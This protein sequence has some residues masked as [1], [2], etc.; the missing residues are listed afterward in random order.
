MDSLSQIFSPSHSPT[1]GTTINQIKHSTD[2]VSCECNEASPYTI[3]YISES[4]PSE[5]ASMR[6][7]NHSLLFY[8]GDLF[9]YGGR[10][11]QPTALATAIS[12]TA[13]EISKKHKQQQR[14]KTNSHSG[15]PS[16]EVHLPSVYPTM[17]SFD[18]V[19]SAEF[20]DFGG[21]SGSQVAT[22]K[23]TTSEIAA[24]MAGEYI[25]GVWR[26][27]AKLRQWRDCQEKASKNRLLAAASVRLESNSSSPA[28][29]HF[30]RK[31]QG[32]DMPYSVLN[33]PTI[34][35]FVETHL[36]TPP[37]KKS[38]SSSSSIG[39][40][41]ALAS[42][43][44]GQIGASFVDMFSPP[45]PRGDH[46][47]NIVGHHMLI[48]GG[49]KYRE[50][51]DDLFAFDF[52][53]RVWCQL[54]HEKEFGPGPTFSHASVVINTDQDFMSGMR[55]RE[56]HSP[57]IRRQNA[58]LFVM[59]G[60]S[61]QVR[62]GTQ[63]DGKMLFVYDCTKNHWDSFPGPSKVDPSQ[64]H[65][66]EMAHVPCR[67][68]NFAIS[69]PE[70][71]SD[72][73][74]QPRFGFGK[75]YVIGLDEVDPRRTDHVNLHSAWG[76][77]PFGASGS[78]LENQDSAHRGSHSFHE[79]HVNTRRAGQ[80]VFAFD[81]ATAVWTKIMTHASPKSPIPFRISELRA[82][83]RYT[84]LLCAG[85][86]HI[87]TQNQW[88]FML[89]APPPLPRGAGSD[90]ISS[91]HDMDV[92]YGAP[93][94]F[95][96]PGKGI[97]PAPHF[98]QS[99]I[100]A[101]NGV[102]Q[103][104]LPS[105]PVIGP[106]F[107]TIHNFV[108]RRNKQH[109]IFGVT[110][111]NPNKG[112]ENLDPSSGSN[113]FG[114]RSTVNTSPLATLPPCVV[115]TFCFNTHQ[116]SMNSVTDPIRN[117]VVEA[118]VDMA[119]RSPKRP[120]A[121]SSEVQHPENSKLKVS[122]VDNTTKSGK[123]ARLSSVTEPRSQTLTT[124]KRKPSLSRTSSVS[125]LSDEPALCPS[126]TPPSAL[127]NPNAASGR[128]TVGVTVLSRPASPS[129]T[130]NAERQIT[131]AGI[132]KKRQSLVVP[133]FV[134]PKEDDEHAPIIPKQ[135]P[136][137][138]LIHKQAI[139][140]LFNAHSEFDHSKPSDSPINPRHPAPP[141][142]M[143]KLH[144]LMRSSD[145]E[146]L[147]KGLSAKGH[148]GKNSA[149]PR[150]PRIAASILNNGIPQSKG[151]KLTAIDAGSI[152]VRLRQMQVQHQNPS[153][154]THKAR[155]HTPT[156]TISEPSI[157]QASAVAVSKAAAATMS[158]KIIDS[159][160]VGKPFSLGM[161]SKFERKYRLCTAHIFAPSK[162][163]LENDKHE[164]M[165]TIAK[166]IFILDQVSV[167]SNVPRPI[168]SKEISQTSFHPLSKPDHRLGDNNPFSL[169][170]SNA[171][172]NICVNFPD[173]KHAPREAEDIR[174]SL[175]A[176]EN[177]LSK[178]MSDL[179]SS[180]VPT[181]ASA[182]KLHATSIASSEIILCVG[183]IERFRDICFAQLA[184][185]SDASVGA[186]L[187]SFQY[188]APA[189]GDDYFGL[190]EANRSRSSALQSAR[191]GTQNAATPRVAI[192]NSPKKNRKGNKTAVGPAP[193][194]G[195][196]SANDHV[197]SKVLPPSDVRLLRAALSTIVKERP[198]DSVLAST[199]DDNDDMIDP[200]VKRILR[201][202]R[203]AESEAA[204][205]SQAAAGGSLFRGTLGPA[206]HSEFS[207]PRRA[208]VSPVGSE[209]IVETHPPK[210]D[211]HVNLQTQKGLPQSSP[212]TARQRSE[213]TT[214]QRPTPPNTQPVHRP[215]VPFVSPPTSTRKTPADATKKSSAACREITNPQQ[216]LDLAHLGYR[217]ERGWLREN[218]VSNHP[219]PI[220]IT[221]MSAPQ[222]PDPKAHPFNKPP[223]GFGVDPFS[224]WPNM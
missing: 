77:R 24:A 134:E 71:S 177:C 173:R 29:S 44:N 102:N 167:L 181:S 39:G 169:E 90:G 79:T 108:S 191:S 161:F 54:R 160:Y 69:T 175:I 99:H 197:H 219:R 46:S 222:N 48:F 86:A 72:T 130:P 124:P 150:A 122:L 178:K 23:T 20:D 131:H 121:N 143:E 27:D 176:A 40:S 140:Q 216:A 138:E 43:V 137:E 188:E 66:V 89:D 115:F 135:V 184:S 144:A 36:R 61:T 132:H 146:L 110:D 111:I 4:P 62:T 87:T 51:Y 30:S 7:V 192:P 113:P 205:I 70:S 183:G 73:R 208:M 196:K 127:K 200:H 189:V 55:P 6:R 182:T 209:S 194:G 199:Q 151:N 164:R 25:G 105:Q 19:F 107:F 52:K 215:F 82:C 206:H 101:D 201:A 157:A 60:V 95:T 11:I 162:I 78:E 217:N 41:A 35:S 212:T 50:V 133:Q 117:R 186:F 154:G 120:S 159:F 136:M 145:E 9:L 190:V 88:V 163:S 15:D 220:Q 2:D 3:K 96:A 97:T 34:D 93:D 155:P 221:R 67:F 63:L 128:R 109:A 53:T 148:E 204:A 12:G 74:V 8:R 218:I 22:P 94:P 166:N 1:H 202:G 47:A 211:S 174:S 156:L 21:S 118:S 152:L 18:D 185:P 224:L 179:I 198:L 214:V 33:V 14:T 126:P 64:I 16:A 57:T 193:L 32:A 83:F 26:Y 58:F 28:S 17:T 141:P 49:R 213:P 103:S 114:V 129:C 84:G 125:D 104:K 172:K 153:T 187:P 223:G 100:V 59:G 112:V 195:D 149:S 207:K 92:F 68:R 142:G 5:S 180:G 31:V 210:A 13:L 75:I 37:T 45:T 56:S 171:T 170:S 123:R 42:A 91:N 116:W 65:I 98:G 10:T 76:T 147:A 80:H 38:P 139:E 106:S 119:L 81:L 165:A 158:D 203:P 168:I 85:A